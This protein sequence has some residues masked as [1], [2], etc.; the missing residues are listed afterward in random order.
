MLATAGEVDEQRWAKEMWFRRSGELLSELATERE[1]SSTATGA[2]AAAKA[3]AALARSEANAAAS[4]V[5]AAKAEAALLEQKCAQL[6][7]A[8]SEIK[9]PQAAAATT[10]LAAAEQAS[11]ALRRAEE[12]AA[13]QRRRAD[14]MRKQVDEL[15][16]AIERRD[17][18]AHAATPAM[19]DELRTLA[20][21][22]ERDAT[23]LAAMRLQRARDADELAALRAE[24]ARQATRSAEELAALRSQYEQRDREARE[25]A[26]LLSAVRSCSQLELPVAATQTSCGGS[27]V[28]ETSSACG[29][30]TADVQLA[31]AAPSTEAVPAIAEFA[32]LATEL[33]SLVRDSLR[34]TL[35]AEMR[36]L[37]DELRGTAVAK[38]EA[39]C[40]ARIA[41]LEVAVGELLGALDAETHRLLT[42]WRGKLES[43]ERE[44]ARLK[45]QLRVHHVESVDRR[46][47]GLKAA[48]AAGGSVLQ[49]M[50]AAQQQVATTAQVAAAPPRPSQPAAAPTSSLGAA[51]VIV[52]PPPPPL[53][54]GAGPAEPRGVAALAAAAPASWPQWAPVADPRTGAWTGG[55]CAVPTGPRRW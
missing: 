15:S 39:A 20:E 30:S 42:K 32:G 41:T 22:R 24:L 19:T 27:A 10:S 28:A 1:K 52:A 53:T 35:S 12:E 26:E 18:E 47:H 43:V 29:A 45:E 38:A 9:A 14:S 50:W 33:S 4:E 25:M 55:Y 8:L 13:Q 37:V 54:H 34:S 16:S 40:D 44:N 7:R 51:A 6:E 46:T 21:G 11:E 31:S 2:A 48:G 3:E 23:Q 36:H 49:G 17:R 5:K